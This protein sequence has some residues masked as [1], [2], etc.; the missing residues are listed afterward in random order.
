M[1]FFKSGR[2]MY[3][4]KVYYPV[5][6]FSYNWGF[7]HFLTKFINIKVHLRRFQSCFNCHHLLIQRVWH[8]EHI[9]P[10]KL[11]TLSQFCN[12]LWQIIALSA[13]PTIPAGDW[14]KSWYSPIGPM[15]KTTVPPLCFKPG[16]HLSNSSTHSPDTPKALQDLP[17]T[18]I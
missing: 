14:C 10:W 8:E 18:F 17:I 6:G 11:L 7:F 12:C 5:L 16:S 15:W 13:F 1:D 3:N 4:W 9:I 2:A